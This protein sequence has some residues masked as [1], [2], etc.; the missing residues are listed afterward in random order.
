M[1]REVFSLIGRIRTE[2]FGAVK[3]ELSVLDKNIT[4]AANRIDKFGRDVGKIGVNMAKMTAP[5][6]ALG[7][8]AY[9]SVELV[10]DLNETISKTG[11]I[12]GD[13]AGQI[14]DW[15][16]SAAQAFGMSKQQGMD[17]ASTFAIFGKSAGLSGDRLATFSTNFVQLAA[18]FASFHNAKPEEAITAIGAALRGENEPIRRFGILLDDA[19]MRAEALK[20]GLIE[21]TKQAL[22]PQ[23]KVLA[24]QSL[25]YKQSADAQGDFLRTSDGLANQTRILKAEII[26]MATAFGQAFLPAAQQVMTLIRTKLL[27]AVKGAVEWFTNLSPELRNTMI[28]F[29]GIAVAIGPLL[30]GIGKLIGLVKTLWVTV[31]LLN[32]T[33][34]A[35]P[36]GLI[37]TLIGLLGIGVVALVKNFD[38]V[39][40]AFVDL[41]WEI[42][43][44]T[45]QTVSYV[46]LALFKVVAWMIG[47]AKVAAKVI[48]GMAD[49]LAYLEAQMKS[50]AAAEDEQIK[51]R[52]RFRAESKAAAQDTE[53]LAKAVE[54]AKEET[55]KYSATLP[56]L[57]KTRKRDTKATDDQ[58][59]AEKKL[60]EERAKFSEGWTDKLREQIMTRS[61]LLEWEYR[62][63]L[64]R[65]EEL[66]ASRQDIE[67]YYHIQRL[68]L[69]E[70]EA[71]EK[72]RLAQKEVD[73][74]KEKLQ[75]TKSLAM[76]AV[77]QIF[78]L[79]AAATDNE[80]AR[81]DQAA[82]KRK[83][84]IDESVLGEE[85][86]ER[87]K[88][89][90]D[91]QAE[92]KKRNLMREQAKRDKAAAYFAAIIN[93][94]QAVSKAL[95]LGFPL[96]LVMAVLFGVLGIAQVAA[97][98]AEPLPQLAR[99]GVVK[100]SQGGTALV[101]GEGGE[102][103]MILPMQTGVRRVVGDVVNGIRSAL[104][105]PELP[106]SLAHGR[107]A[108]GGVGAGSGGGG[109]H[110]H[111]GTLIADD[112]G[113]RELERRQL[114]FRN[115]EKI[116]KG[117]I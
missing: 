67:L 54:K 70:E 105:G 2:G 84:A 104:A 57:I 16:N 24:A 40:A 98:A 47:V 77:D 18:D 63:A 25:I 8:A 89:A 41:F 97:I 26:D 34:L 113:M 43:Y 7:V 64:S 81:I 106:G 90:I 91:E 102:D 82:E 42:L 99:G 1:S 107:P 10:T 61:Q 12:F 11:E 20:L 101:A 92:K 76:Q 65:A 27:P 116:R 51:R 31:Q 71:N 83:A 19:S 3:K 111:I 75:L 36:I 35:N 37:I 60:S 32:A 103:E 53:K 5:I 109:V 4:K 38:T 96:G 78:A 72:A 93:T 87:Q 79:M 44:A 55:N 6:A 17:A 69:A 112:S 21:T 110:F 100:R 23:E 108:M 88:A 52:R 58:A 85:E 15:S 33:M 28:M 13:A 56:E 66:G 49:K 94:F 29:G 114:K 46:R 95:T 45:R 22:T 14:D 39:K 73:D 117:E 115:Q 62:D 68:R 9:K 86:K 50:L 80:I 30:I 59:K 74:R 48:P